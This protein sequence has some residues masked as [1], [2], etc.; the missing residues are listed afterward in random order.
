MGEGV[1]LLQ[2]PLTETLPA[3]L[4]GLV[5][6]STVIEKLAFHSDDLTLVCKLRTGISIA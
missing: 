3:S 6:L 5:V 2:I 1:V 4:V